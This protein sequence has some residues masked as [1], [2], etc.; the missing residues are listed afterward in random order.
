[1]S[2][3]EGGL[4]MKGVSLFISS[5]SAWGNLHRE[6][7]DEQLRAIVPNCDNGRGSSPVP[8]AAVLARA[9]TY[10]GDLTVYI[11]QLKNGMF[12]AYEMT[13]A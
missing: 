6:G 7:V 3:V 8:K 5:M 13:L 9:A 2:S 11:G 4:S 10:V 1:M 12:E